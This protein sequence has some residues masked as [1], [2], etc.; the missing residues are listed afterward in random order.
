MHK[1]KCELCPYEVEDPE[2]DKV[3]A[4]RD[5]HMRTKHDSTQVVPASGPRPKESTGSTLADV[6]GDVV[7]GLFSGI[8][9]IFD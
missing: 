4:L 9:K 2:R 8:A 3:P 1:W 7:E 6:V 5:Y